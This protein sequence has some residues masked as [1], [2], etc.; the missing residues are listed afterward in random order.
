MK[1][2][3]VINIHQ[4]A[5]FSKTGSWFARN[6]APTNRLI[7]EG[8]NALASEGWIFEAAAGLHGSMIILSRDDLSDQP[9]SNAFSQPQ[10][11]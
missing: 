5:Q 11:Y 7:E 2:Y 10:K 8:L 4:L 9:I 3:K 1:T 6:I